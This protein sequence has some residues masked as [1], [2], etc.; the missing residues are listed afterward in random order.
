MD[1]R[2]ALIQ[3]VL[4]EGNYVNQMNHRSDPVNQ[5]YHVNHLISGQAA[6]NV[7]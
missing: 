6:G 7:N 2:I 4:N 5:S 1:F 3:V